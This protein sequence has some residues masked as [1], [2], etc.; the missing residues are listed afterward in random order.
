IIYNS[1]TFTIDDIEFQNEGGELTISGDNVITITD[2][3]DFIDD[4]TILTNNSTA[5]LDIQN[6]I[7]FSSSSS[8]VINNGTINITQ[9]I[10]VDQTGNNNNIVSNNA[11]AVL[12]IGNI[13]ECSN[14]VFSI[15]NS[16]TINQTGAFTN[17]VQIFNRN[18]ATWNYSDATF[19][20]NIELF[21]DFG[22][23][24]FNYNAAGTQDIHI[25]EDAYR[26]LS[27]SNGGIKTSLG[28]LEV[29]GN[30]SISGTATLDANDNDINLAGDW[31]NT[32]TFDHGS[33]PP[34]GSQTV[35]FDG[36]GEQTISNASGETF[37]NLTINNADTGVV[38]SNG[39]VI[40]E[41]TL[42]M[43]QGNID[44]GTWTLTLGTDEVA[45]DEGTLSHTSGTIIGKFKRWIIATS[46]DIL[47]PVGTD[48]TENFSTINFTDLTSGSLTVEYNPSDPGSAGLPLNESLYIFRNQ[49]T[50]G[51]WDIT[52]ANTLSS[53]DYNIE[54]VADGFNDFSILPASR[55]LARTNGGD[56]ELRGNHADAI[57]DT[58]FRNG[59]TGDISTLG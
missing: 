28:N 44:P 4:N 58:V 13:V 9:N 32:G 45:G 49:F 16:G 47:F 29:N 41:E 27:L 24:T 25:P 21:S 36:I 50:E 43:T 59:V 52:S 11:G 8:S 31:T 6:Q 39:D 40:V 18:A 34:G 3:V 2:L 1:G 35:T 20:A 48:T 37:D 17:E 12:N 56:W 5:N 26:N 14:T 22:T 38:F 57:P 10:W 54:L 53:T 23:N 51:Y 19:N 42:N 55:V 15:D 33:P 46:T 7:F 30:L